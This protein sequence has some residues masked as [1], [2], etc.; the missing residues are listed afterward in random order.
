MDK[1][2]PFMPSIV[3][4]SQEDWKKKNEE[5]KMRRCE[6]TMSLAAKIAP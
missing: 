5:G 2:K 3:K 1:R 4:R 6:S